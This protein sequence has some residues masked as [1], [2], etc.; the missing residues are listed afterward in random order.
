L[1]RQKGWFLAKISTKA[2]NLNCS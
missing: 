1:I 2:I